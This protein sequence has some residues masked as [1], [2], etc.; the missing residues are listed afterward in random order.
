[1][2]YDK[3]KV[4]IDLEEYNMF[5]KKQ[6]QDSKSQYK[7][8]LENFIERILSANKHNSSF[9]IE[10]ISSIGEHLRESLTANGLILT[11]NNGSYTIKTND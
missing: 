4:T 2:S 8:A 6:D 7:L 9:P 11:T 5:L 3:P 10:G 1:M